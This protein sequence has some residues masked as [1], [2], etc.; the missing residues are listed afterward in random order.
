MLKKIDHFGLAA[1]CAL[2]YWLS[3]QQTLPTPELFE[4]Q[5]KAHHLLAYFGMGVMCWR[6]FRH[7]MHSP[8]ILAIV[9]IAF[10]SAYGISDEWHQ[11]FV[12][13]RNASV[14]DWLADTLGAVFAQL[15][16]LKYA[17][18]FNNPTIT[19]VA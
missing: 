17:A 6:S 1:Y 7:C 9:A 3:S 12:P 8:I 11:T 18:K 13:G 10:C 19:G 15:L 14:Y 2:I 5:D 4:N 16:L